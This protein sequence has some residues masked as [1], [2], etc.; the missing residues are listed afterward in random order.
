MKL[1]HFQNLPQYKLNSKLNILKLKDWNI[2]GR[3]RE[4][5]RKGLWRW[6]SMSP[7]IYSKVTAKKHKYYRW[8]PVVRRGHLVPLNNQD[9]L[10]WGVF[11][12]KIGIWYIFFGEDKRKNQKYL[13]LSSDKFSYLVKSVFVDFILQPFQMIPTQN[14]KYC[15]RLFQYF[16]QKIKQSL[17]IE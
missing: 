1:I 11:V 6:S 16:S 10:Y 4:N 9:Y 3:P 12:C 2:K 5:K 15:Q 7:G 8:Y 14:V 13:D 17:P